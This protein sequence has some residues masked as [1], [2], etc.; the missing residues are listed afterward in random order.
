MTTNSP[1]TE[2]T[3]R[4]RALISFL[5]DITCGEACWHAK[6]EICRCSCGGKNHGCLLELDGSRPVR[7]CRMGGFQYEL[8]AVGTWE[9]IAIDARN[10]NNAHFPAYVDTTRGTMGGV[11]QDMH[12]HY[13]YNASEDGAPARVK[14]ATSPQIGKWAELSAWLDKTERPFLLWRRVGAPAPSY[15]ASGCEKCDKLKAERQAA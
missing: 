6:E 13:G 11:E 1:I 10:I 5:S 15:H 4:R 2:P 14:G 9:Q 3:N 7:S 8:A 12:Y